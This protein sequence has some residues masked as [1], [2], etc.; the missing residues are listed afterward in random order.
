MNVR[1]RRPCLIEIGDA[2]QPDF[3]ALL[4]GQARLQASVKIEL[5]CPLDGG[6]IPLSR[7][8]AD[9]IARLTAHD[10]HAVA[11]LAADGPLDA[12]QIEALAARGALVSDADSAQAAALRDG[13]ARL[14]AV[15]WHPLA[16][17]YHAMSRW[18]G[19]VGDEGTRDHDDAAHRA[20]LLAYIEKRGPPPPHFVR[21]GD[22]HARFPLPPEPLDD[23]FAQVLRARRTTRHFDQ[24]A[25]LSLV[26]FSRVLYGTF[27]AI[28]TAELAPGAIAVKRTSASGGALHPVEAYPLVIR[29]E[30]LTPGFYHYETGTHTLALLQPL[31]EAEARAQ[32]AALTIGQLYF[33]E[34]HALVFH[35]ARLDRHHWKYRRH[36]KAYK[37]ALL[38]SGHLSQTFYLLAAERGLGAFYTAAINDADIT[39]RL[40]LDPLSE[41]VIGASGTGIIDPTRHILH[42]T[43][44]PYAPA[45]AE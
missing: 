1:R 20:R 23:A 30:G 2:L 24:D 29:V 12:Q 39:E 28:G 35:V 42:F 5:L 26:D 33:A 21:R 27:G 34:A 15:G 43:P 19:V 38:D 25:T 11:T 22:A 45:D 10:W 3:A 8:E 13:E 6:R 4:R 9:L 18:R 37:A 40:R 16:A 41:I 32:A 7:E 14:E 36:V 17:V 44:Q 31:T